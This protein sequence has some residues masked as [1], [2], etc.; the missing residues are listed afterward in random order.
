MPPSPKKRKL[1]HAQHP[2]ANIIAGF[3]GAPAILHRLYTSLCTACSERSPCQQSGFCDSPIGQPLRRIVAS[4]V[5]FL[6][7]SRRRD[8]RLCLG[9]SWPAKCCPAANG[10]R[11]HGPDQHRGSKSF[12]SS[13]SRAPDAQGSAFVGAAV[14]AKPAAG[15]Q[16]RAG[17]R[18]QQRLLKQKT[19]NA[20]E[21][22]A[23][24]AFLYVTLAIPTCRYSRRSALP[25][26]RARR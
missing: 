4:D 24:V 7:N 25:G 9:T 12:G 8:E 3:G 19:E 14:A 20:T 11:H 15:R 21:E 6:P 2:D 17:N 16:R 22:R 1:A 10:A 23:S 13:H 18:A 5:V 26:R